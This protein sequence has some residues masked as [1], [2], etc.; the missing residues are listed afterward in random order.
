[1]NSW[2]DDIVNPDINHSM[3]DDN[4]DNVIINNKT[5]PA[6]L[7]P[8]NAQDPTV[9]VAF[10]VASNSIHNYL[11]NLFDQYIANIGN[12]IVGNDEGEVDNATFKQKKLQLYNMHV[13][14]AKH[15]PKCYN[16]QPVSA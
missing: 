1:M 8:A 6:A 10:A 15:H 9:K 12:S 7:D 5:N 3:T 13:S 4:N 16:Y 2:D 11:Y 14:V